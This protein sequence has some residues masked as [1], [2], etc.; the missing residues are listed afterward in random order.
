VLH[1]ADPSRGC[2]VPFIRAI[3][4]WT[5]TALVINSIIGS[6]IFGLPSEVTRLV[7]RASPLAMIF[8]GLAMGII[9]A[10]L[11]EVASQFSEPGGVY[12]Y[13][14]TAFGRFAGMQAGWFHLLAACAGGAANASLF[15]IYLAGLLPWAG[16]GTQHA[17]L[18]ALLIIVPT[19]ANYVGVRSGA[20]FSNLLTIAKLLPLGLIIA[21]GIARFGHH[22]EILKRSEISSPGIASWLS[23]LFLL[24]FAYGG[25]ENALVPAGE[26][27]NPRQTVPFGLLAGLVVCA[28]VYT[29][30]QFVTVATI[31][32]STTP[33]PLAETASV[34]VGQSGGILLTI[35][36]MI[37]AYGWLSGGLLEV[38]RLA[39]SL[40]A[41]GDAPGFLGKLHPRFKTPAL[42]IVL[43]A[44][45]IWFLAA[46]GAYLW[47][48]ALGSGAFIVIYS[49]GCAALIKLRRQNPHADALR[50]PFGQAFALLAIFICLTVLTRLHA[51]EA[52]LMGVTAMIA[53][54]NWWWAKH[55]ETQR[56]R[57]SKAVIAAGASN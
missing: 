53:T 28:A 24:F 8:G 38:P 20:A 14:R 32:T 19:A 1:C 47:I 25:P 31:G 5:M 39:C 9:M 55:R 18:L 34:L 48:A 50:L 35:G 26:V 10:C 40:A 57:A 27:K 44:A 51:R 21:L 23:A 11:A 6:G 36:V 42:A 43:Y 16:G 2:G 49:A 37:S 30:V 46:T 4:R 29:L 41:Q 7:G 15:M 17:L 13:V 45:F 56:Q 3:G 12:L 22:I 54:A 52:L 33:R